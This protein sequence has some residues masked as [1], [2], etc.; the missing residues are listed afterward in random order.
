[1]PEEV[2]ETYNITC[3]FI[4]SSYNIVVCKSV[5]NVDNCI[6]LVG[7]VVTNTFYRSLEKNHS[8]MLYTRTPFDL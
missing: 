7:T 8:S 3:Y 2:H 5:K 1:M 4:T 6:L